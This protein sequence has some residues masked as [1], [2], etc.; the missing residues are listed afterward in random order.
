MDVI[1]IS[2]LAVNMKSFISSSGCMMVV[3]KSWLNNPNRSSE[4]YNDGLE[5][6]LEMC[7][8]RVDERGFVFCPCTKCRNSVM[9]SLL[10][11][12]FHLY[13]WG[14]QRSYSDWIY[15][16]KRTTPQ[17][18]VVDDGASGNDMA[19]V[20][21][22]GTIGSRAAT[23]IRQL[24]EEL[25]SQTQADQVTSSAD[26]NEVQA[27]K[28]IIGTRRGRTQGVGFKPST[29]ASVTHGQPPPTLPFTQEQID[30]LFQDP[31]FRDQLKKF[32]RSQK[33]KK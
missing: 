24:E 27:S 18:I 28:N 16:I 21:K 2:L 33:R 7:K 9:L 23:T 8:D 29:Q 11:V 14:F 26:V 4:E 12:K 6:F 3:D 13:A 1:Y 10:K 20:I 32:I 22:N 30:M 17:V 15:H 25:A 5:S 31:Y 19:G